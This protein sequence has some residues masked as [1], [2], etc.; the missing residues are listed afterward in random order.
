MSLGEPQLSAALNSAYS[1]PLGAEVKE[2]SVSWPYTSFGKSAS[3]ASTT[4]DPQLGSTTVQFTNG[5]RLVVKPTTYEKDK[6]HVAVSFGNGRAGVSPKLARALWEIQLYPLSR[7]W[8]AFAEPDH[9]VGAVERKDR[10]DRARCRGP[11][12]RTQGHDTS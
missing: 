2:A 5:T 12:L 1:R 3:V 8:Q 11:S 4:L 9:P 10:D 6:V 7:H